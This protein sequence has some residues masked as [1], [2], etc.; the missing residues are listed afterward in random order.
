MF[1][2]IIV[3]IIIASI[4]DFNGNDGIINGVGGGEDVQYKLIC[5]LFVCSVIVLIIIASIFDFNVKG[6]IINGRGGGGGRTIQAY[7]SIICL[8]QSLFS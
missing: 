7:M 6:G 4:F 1:V 3:L 2:S 8:F 5:R